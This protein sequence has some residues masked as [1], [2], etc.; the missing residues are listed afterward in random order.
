V[1]TADTES[2]HDQ[3]LLE[4][5]AE[6]AR[7]P[8]FD[9]FQAQLRSSG[10]CAR[11]VRLRG[12]VCDGHGHRI[13]S[14]D[15]EP[16]GVLRKACGNRREAVCPSCAERYRQDA[17]HLIAA[18]LRGGK[19]VPDSVS[20]HPFVFAT[21]TAPSFGHVHARVLDKHGNPRRCR[22]RRDHPVC[23]HGQPLS[24]GQTHGEDD[25]CL[26][27]PLCVECFD[28][29]AAVVWNNTI[30]KLWWRTTTYL[31]RHLAAV[32][33]VTQ[34]RLGEM[35]WVS[36]VKVAEYQA[37]GL[38][39]FHAVFRIDRAMPKYREHEVRP[40]DPRFT[41]RLLEHAVNSALDAVDAPIAEDLASQLGKRRVKWG[42][43]RDVRPVENASELAGYLAKYSTK[44]T[45]QVG[46]GLLHRIDSDAV[47]T[48]NVSDHVRGYLRAAFELHD[49]AQVATRKRHEQEREQERQ[50][51]SAT[52][53]EQ[54]TGAT[55]R[56]DGAAG[57]AWHATQAIAHDQYVRVRL[58][59]GTE[60]TGRITKRSIAEKRAT[61]EALAI[62][63]NGETIHL[64]EIDLIA[65]VPPPQPR[66]KRDPHDPR[67]AANAHKLGYRG[68]CLTKSQRWSTTFTALRQAR[69]RHVHEQLVNAPG[70]TESQRKLLQLD[71]QARVSQFEFVGVGHLTTA[72][73]YLAAQA[74]AMA[75]E[76]RV[77]ARIDRYTTTQTGG[78]T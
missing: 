55:T 69:E 71:P 4:G 38:V 75:R 6:R 46:G 63:L 68:H 42:K 51:V 41:S 61:D 23:P 8:G 73:A 70:V 64:A 7:T 16:D 47:E 12:H 50:R 25:S 35:A 10:Y 52:S 22:P 58:L 49:R 9:R 21:L 15:S 3:A 18:G 54:R 28:H 43:Q 31:P 62:T 11:P 33:G 59:D 13:W 53:M 45:E 37:R 65:P 48:V 14:T 29:E 30:S 56:R 72:D 5:I 44:S 32:L 24:C 34:K 26:G 78:S 40:P 39:H 20:A 17:Y 76:A 66:P 19:G 2:R 36:C 1:T 67:L 77:L 60:H 27:Q 74:A 57:V